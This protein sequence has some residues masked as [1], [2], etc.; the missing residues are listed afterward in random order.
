MIKS[1]VLVISLAVASSYPA[2]ASILLVG[3]EEISGS[4]FGNLP[5]ALTIQSHGPSQPTEAGCIAPDGSGGLIAGKGACAPGNSGGDETN[6]I[7][8]PK[9]SA[10]TLSSLGI[11]NANQIGILFDAVQPQNSDNNVVTINDLTLKLY[12]GATLILTAS[13]AF[14]NLTTNPGNGNT[15]Y[16]F[17]LDAAS[18][19]VFNAAIGG[20]FGYRIALD[21]AI[22]FPRQS[23]G[24]DSYAFVNRGALGI[25][26]APEPFSFSLVAGGLIGL[27]L[28]RRRQIRHRT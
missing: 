25:Q 20:N 13:G 6:P 2:L 3:P 8:F 28:L 14:S 24:P 17:A 1:T 7:G 23:A 16:L 9:Q 12:N 5:R 4:G 19:A 26:T 10:P 22:S 21:S 11:T 15:D 27:A 18:T